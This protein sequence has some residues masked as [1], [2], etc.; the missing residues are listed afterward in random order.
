KNRAG[1][2]ANSFLF[3]FIVGV[4]SLVGF[5]FS[6]P[7]LERSF[8]SPDLGSVGPLLG[9]YTFFMVSS[10]YAEVALVSDNRTNAAAVVILLNEVFKAVALIGGA[11][12]IR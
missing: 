6:G 9:L 12:I 1:Y 3:L 11:L 7:L 4:L 10:L 8:Q 2:L 5:Y